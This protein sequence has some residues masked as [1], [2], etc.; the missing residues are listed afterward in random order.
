MQFLPYLTERIEEIN[1][2]MLD[3]NVKF[4]YKTACHCSITDA[5]AGVD[6][7]IT[8]K[9]LNLCGDKEILL[10]ELLK[11]RLDLTENKN[12]KLNSRGIYLIKDKQM[13][14]FKIQ[15]N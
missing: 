13:D 11:N 3:L 10:S 12:F 7:N 5:S 4:S 9:I 1:K 2:G 14:V 15:F 6:F 8:S